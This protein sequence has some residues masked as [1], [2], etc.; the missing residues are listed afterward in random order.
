MLPCSQFILAFTSF[1]IISC[2]QEHKTCTCIFCH[3]N[4]AINSFTL[5]YSMLTWF[6]LSNNTVKGVL[7]ICCSFILYFFSFSS[8]VNVY[9]ATMPTWRSR[10]RSW[11]SS[12]GNLS[13]TRSIRFWL[14]MFSSSS[15][16]SLTIY[17]IHTNM[18]SLNITKK[19]KAVQGSCS[20]SKPNGCQQDFWKCTNAESGLVIVAN[21][22][23]I[24]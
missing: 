23:V 14:S 6:N 18:I 21:V 3:K 20:V 17:K 12:W 16:L 19:F 2:K 7:V 11:R 9:K 1:P 24:H 13:C 15:S 5:L 4:C 8:W 22:V 10:L